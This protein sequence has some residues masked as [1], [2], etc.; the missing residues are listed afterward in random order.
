MTANRIPVFVVEDQ[1]D[2]RAAFEELLVPFTSLEV[3]GSYGTAEA[4]LNEIINKAP[5][6]IFLDIELPRKS[7]FDFLQD[8]KQFNKHPCIIF[9]TAFDK[10]ALQAIKH[11][12]FDYLLK[13][14]NPDEL[15][16]TINRFLSSSQQCAIEDKIDRLLEYINPNRK[17]RFNTSHGFILISPSEI[18]YCQADWNYTE[19]YMSKE[20]KECV[21]MNIGSLEKML[22]SDQFIRVNRSILINKQFIEK[23]DRKRR[24]IFLKASDEIFEFKASGTALK[25][26]KNMQFSG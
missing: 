10:Y 3:V 5:Q 2:C 22:P 7:G 1:A 8:L 9:T 15:T 11:A 24:I 16:I 20:N 4:A 21:T 25:I 17:I 26:L 14:I 12:A 18:V 13:P 6:I 23:F 19:I